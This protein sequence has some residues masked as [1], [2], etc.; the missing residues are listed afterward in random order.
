[1]TWWSFL[2]WGAVGGAVVEA[3]E[4]YTC[5]RHEGRLPW[6]RTDKSPS[7]TQYLVSIVVRIALGA[8]MATGAGLSGQVNGTFGALA[9]GVAAPVV[10][11]RLIAREADKILAAESPSV[12]RPQAKHGQPEAPDAISRR[13]TE[14][15]EAS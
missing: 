10:V 5:V 8:G 9:L 6:N 15:G 2:I 14:P 3:A 7:A 4:F 11:E 12:S 1:M 13:A